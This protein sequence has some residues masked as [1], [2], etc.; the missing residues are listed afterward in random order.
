[1]ATRYYEDY[2]DPYAEPDP[3]AQLEE[4]E[5]PAAPAPVPAPALA[6]QQASPSYQAPSGISQAWADD[7]L[8][9]NPGD[10]HRVASA[11][12]SGGGAP[13][14]PMPAV[15]GTVGGQNSQGGAPSGTQQQLIDQLMG[16]LTQQYQP[17]QQYGAE[18][19]RL[20]QAQE[21]RAAQE[22][23][24]RAA[25]EDQFRTTLME[26]IKR[27]QEPIDYNAAMNTPE[28]KGFARVQERAQER[29]RAQA[30]EQRAAQGLGQNQFGEVSG[31]LGSD[32]QQGETE[33]AENIAGFQSKL[34]ADQINRR[35]A[36]L[37]QALQLGAGMLSGEQSND[38]R[39]ELSQ[40]DAALQRESFQADLGL[41]G[42]LGGGQLSL[43]L[44]DSLMGNDRYY[45]GLN[46]QG[47]Q[48]DRG[49]AAEMERFNRGLTSQNDQFYSGLGANLGY[50]QALLN[51]NPFQYLFG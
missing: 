28:A 27:G 39:R 37:M 40:L 42:Q 47:G 48:F 25:Q 19:M 41:R 24:R 4:L 9:R 17:Q 26:M 15:P 29:Y 50:Q 6:P 43:G 49:L 20:M 31:A 23:Q 14:Q 3:D 12:G 13:S 38:L 22:A 10:T 51:Q 30:A 1:M 44:L 46:Q 32:I 2:E 45:A 33:V 21:A 7:F 16:R 11:Y 8:R 34:I 36:E 35:R 18:V 5:P